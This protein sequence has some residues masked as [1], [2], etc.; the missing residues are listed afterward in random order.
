[1]ADV[2]G[3]LH[4][5]SLNGFWFNFEW[6]FFKDLKYF[7]P[8]S[9]SVGDLSSF[10]I[11]IGRLLVCENSQICYPCIANKWIYLKSSFNLALCLPHFPLFPALLSL[12]LVVTCPI[13][14]SSYHTLSPSLSNMYVHHYQADQP[15]LNSFVY[16]CWFQRT[17]R[18][19]LSCRC[20]AQFWA[21]TK[22]KIQRK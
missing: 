19:A 5:N 21:N 1:M 8:Q 7:G 16:F 9:L 3:L 6:E 14:Y 18:L 17:Y 2:A 11:F 12:V 13:A 15:N 10:G 22:P 4:D 20:L